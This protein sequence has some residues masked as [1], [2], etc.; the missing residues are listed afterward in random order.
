MKVLIYDIETLK[1]L[2][3][4]N[5]Y[6]P[7]D[8][9]SYEFMVCKY[10]DNLNQFIDF[11]DQHKEYYWVGYNNLRFDAQVVTHVYRRHETYNSLTALE[12][13][14]KISQYASDTISD[15]NYDKFAE[16]REEELFARQIDLFKIH[17][18]D[19]KNRRV[20]L[21]R[22]EFEMDLENIEEMPI[23]HLKTNM[24][25]EE[26]RVTREYCTNDVHATYQFY[27]ITIGKTEHPLYKDDNRIELRLDIEQEFGIPC[28][29]YSDSKIGDEMIK[30]YYCEEKRIKYEDLP[31][32]EIGRAHV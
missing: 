23:H 1:E 28:L 19:N 12:A 10:Y 4:V 9:K 15:M 2:F 24:S 32:Q 22:L 18:Y 31:R 30:K 6:D 16:Y 27:L 29:N 5:I 14:A 26:V 20:S 25:E 8:D 11:I 17:H 7:Q 3:L 13:C 21:K